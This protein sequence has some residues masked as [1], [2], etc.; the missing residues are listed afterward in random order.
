[1]PRGHRCRAGSGSRTPSLSAVRRPRGGLRPVCTRLTSGTAPPWA[2][3]SHSEGGPDGY[4]DSSASEAGR[5]ERRASVGR[6]AHCLSLRKPSAA[7]RAIKLIKG[8]CRGI[9][10]EPRGAGGRQLHD[11][12][13]LVRVGRHTAVQLSTAPDSRPSS[14]PPRI[15]GPGED[16]GL[17]SD[18]NVE[19]RQLTG[20]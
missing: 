7:A 18:Q 5:S 14:R 9:T 6:Q 12:S 1:M 4:V 19:C 17:F 11:R 10:L 20:P 2:R 13:G 8:A 15:S 16:P 3:Q